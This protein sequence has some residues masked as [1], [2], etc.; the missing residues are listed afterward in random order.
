[1][2][3]VCEH[4]SHARDPLTL[5]T[6]KGSVNTDHIPGSVN[7]GHIPGSMNTDHIP[8]SVNTGHIRGSM[9]TGHIPGSVNTDHISMSV[10]AMS[11]KTSLLDKGSVISLRTGTCMVHPDHMLGVCEHWSHPRVCEHW[12]HPRIC[13]HWSHPRVARFICTVCTCRIRWSCKDLTSIPQQIHW[14]QLKHLLLRHMYNL[15]LPNLC[16]TLLVSLLC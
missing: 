16:A 10:H 14:V 1:M 7:T 8:G 3:W 6:C 15:S 9:N 4:W 13:E 11:L 2:L 5:I 12:A